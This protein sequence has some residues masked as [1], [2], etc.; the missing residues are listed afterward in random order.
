MKAKYVTTELERNDAFFIRKTVFVEEQGIPIQDEFDQ[1]E[2]VANHIV[3]Y[4]NEEP[5][6]A[7]RLRI[8]DNVAKL[9]RICVLASYRKYGV[10]KLIVTTME[11]LGKEKG[12]T[13]AMLHGQTQAEHFYK[14]LGYHTITEPFMEDGI[15]HVIMVKELL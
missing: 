1:Y 4:N 6:G 9:E 5:V 8:V 2:D 11:D 7:G 13:K 3:I 10:G 15:P 14:K 12:M